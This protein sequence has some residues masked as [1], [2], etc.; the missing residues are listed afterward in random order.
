M[1]NQEVTQQDLLSD[2][3]NPFFEY[4]KATQG[5]RFLNFLIDNVFIRLTLNYTTGIAIGKILWAIL[6]DFMLYLAR[7]SNTFGLY[8]FSFI[9][10][11]VS[12]LF[13]YTL[14]EKIFKGKTLGKLITGTRAVKYNGE[15]LSFRDAFLRSA[16]RLIPFEV[17][18]GFGEPWHDS[19]TNTMVIQ[20]R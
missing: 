17:L 16:C 12:Y 15:E 11:I 13:Y 2:P 14:C 8:V 19:I 7:D 18:S 6:P 4:T 10:V 5:Q 20:T 1:E 9:I 3:L